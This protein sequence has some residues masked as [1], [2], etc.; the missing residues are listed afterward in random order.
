MSASLVIRVDEQCPDVA[1]H[2]VADPEGNNLSL[3]F[4]HPA[5]S[6]LLDRFPHHLVGDDDRHE[7]IL[8]DRAPH[9]LNARD[10]GCNGL[11]QH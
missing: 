11:S 2:R 10:V 8:A 6:R 4:H 7:T 9:A 1:V 5:T 3:R